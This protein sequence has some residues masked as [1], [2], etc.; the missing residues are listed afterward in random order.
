MHRYQLAKSAKQHQDVYE[1][2][3]LI[4]DLTKV[5]ERMFLLRRNKTNQPYHEL[6]FQVEFSVTSSLEYA[7]T[8]DGTRYGSVTAR[9]T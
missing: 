2:A 8:I 1:V 9:Y 3:K 6:N 7:V 4:V 5:P